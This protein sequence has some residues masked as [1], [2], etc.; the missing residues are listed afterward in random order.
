MSEKLNSEQIEAVAGGEGTCTVA[1]EVARA[2]AV[3]PSTYEALI[4]FTS[5][6]IERVVT[7]TRS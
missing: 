7:A 3:L 4:A 6:V 5:D 2:V 1:E